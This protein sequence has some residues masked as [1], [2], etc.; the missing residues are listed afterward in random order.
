M[1]Q[2]REFTHGSFEA[3]LSER[4]LMASRCNDCGEF[5]LPPR[6]LCPRCHGEQMEWVEMSG[7][8]TLATFTAVH[9]GLTAMVEA[10][11][12]RTHPYLTG[13]VQLAEGPMISAQ[14]LGADAT[15]PEKVAIGTRARVAF[16]DRGEG[17]SARTFLAFEIAG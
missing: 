7:A 4:R 13:I 5:H 8:G 15:E 10:G 3:F 14:I 11:Y 1:T 17:E 9:V 6:P 16:I 2:D 12:D